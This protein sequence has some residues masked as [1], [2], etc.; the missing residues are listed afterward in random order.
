MLV[1]TGLGRGE[2]VAHDAGDIG[3]RSGF[4]L[5]ADGGADLSVLLG[6]VRS[7]GASGYVV[8]DNE[9]SRN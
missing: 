1:D 8:G 4:A 5:K 7:L 6:G 2:E 3:Q 9:N